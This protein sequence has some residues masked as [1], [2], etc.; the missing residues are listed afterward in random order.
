MITQHAALL[1]TSYAAFFLAVVTGVVF[2]LQE[3]RLK[4]KDPRVLEAKGLPLELLDRI[5]WWAVLAGF[6]L[7]T[8]GTIDGLFLARENWGSFWSGD[9]KEVWTFVTLAAYAGVLGLRLTVG[10]RGRRVIFMSV[11]SFLLVIFT[12]VGVNHL[13]GSRHNFF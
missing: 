7:Y 8:I 6:V 10:L 13:L 9:P 11:M 5:N 2:L 3:N 12:C 1:F 4:R